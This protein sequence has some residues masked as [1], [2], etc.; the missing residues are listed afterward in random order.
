VKKTLI[1]A[2]VLCILIMTIIS[3]CTTGTKQSQNISSV[4][5]FPVQKDGYEAL[6]YPA[7]LAQ[8]KLVLNNGYLRLKPSV[9]SDDG[10]LIIWPPGSTLKVAN[11]VIQVVNR[12]GV[13]IGE[14]GKTLQ[15]GGGEIPVEI[16]LKYTG[17][18]PPDDCPGPYWLA[19]PGIYNT[20]TATASTGPNP[21]TL[22]EAMRN[23]PMLL[24]AT[25]YAN[26][27][28]VTVDEALKRLEIENSFG[29]T[30]LETELSSQEAETFGGLWIQDE[31]EFK[32]VIAFTRDGEDTLKKHYSAALEPFIPYFEVRTVKVTYI[33]LQKTQ[34]QMTGTL[35][36]LN[37]PADSTVDVLE[38]S[39][40][41]TIAESV[42]S[43]VENVLQSGKLI[44]PDDVH[45][46]YS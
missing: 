35:E 10:D 9:E 28:G 5:F 18:T 32:I 44:V 7:A 14:V 12:E 8:G 23:N 11:N 1:T 30:G 36:T 6:P 38:N 4:T 26:H 21:T 39:V 46:K 13:S 33:E 41:I 24:P 29:E 25:I 34:V 42:R 19:A 2:G 27:Y 20:S 15:I 16:V 37:I 31:P 3:A 45:L 43:Q 17:Q 40:D 22:D